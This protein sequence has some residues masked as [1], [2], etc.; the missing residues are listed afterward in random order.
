M[1]RT[2]KTGSSQK[3]LVPL[4]DQD[5]MKWVLREIG[6]IRGYNFDQSYLGLEDVNL[7]F[8][9][10]RSYSFTSQNRALVSKNVHLGYKLDTKAA[11]IEQHHIDEAR[12]AV[13]NELLLQGHQAKLVSKVNARVKSLLRNFWKYFDDA[14]VRFGPGVALLDGDTKQSGYT[15]SKLEN[16]CAT[17]KLYEYM[18]RSELW[19]DNPF[20]FAWFTRPG[21]NVSIQKQSTEVFFTVPKDCKTDRGCAKQ[22]SVNMTVQLQIGYAL[23]MCLQEVGILIEPYKCGSLTVP[24]QADYHKSILPDQWEKLATIDLKSASNTIS[25][26]LVRLVFPGRIYNLMDAARCSSI[27]IDGEVIPLERFSAMGNGFTFEAE[28][29]LFYAVTDVA[30]NS[31]GNRNGRFRSGSCS[32]FGDDIIVDV[33]DFK[34]ACDA[35]TSLGFEINLKKSFGD[36]PFRESCGMDVY[37]GIPCRPVFLKDFTGPLGFVS[38]HNLI[39]KLSKLGDGYDISYRRLLLQ[40]RAKAPRIPCGPCGEDDDTY[41]HDPQFTDYQHLTFR[42]GNI[43]ITD[44]NQLV[45]R[46]LRV[47]TKRVKPCDDHYFVW[48]WMALGLDSEGYGLRGQTSVRGVR[49]KKSERITPSP[50]V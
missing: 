19:G 43:T 23:R 5:L 3:P 1:K 48:M 39:V 12:C 32:V 47:K 16:P 34:P 18:R 9:D 40:L 35:L 28:S 26:E 14:P 27:D 49:L 24:N 21:N 8:T 45:H 42:V 44:R 36:G 22:P 10:L 25:R 41:F 15:P 31:D 6:S 11:A 33:A 50:W 30:I 38:L 37:Q 2:H 7:D 4:V 46:A 17:L 20:M 29:L 13:Y